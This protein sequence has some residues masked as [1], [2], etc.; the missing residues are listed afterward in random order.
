[1]KNRD[2]EELS[3]K[4][5]HEEGSESWQACNVDT[6]LK[7]IHGQKAQNATDRWKSGLEAVSNYD[8]LMCCIPTTVPLRPSLYH[9]HDVLLL[10]STCILSN[11]VIILPKSWIEQ[12]GASMCSTVL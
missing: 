1:M 2:L 3:W 9:Q 8:G 11:F 4:A 5:K 7:E 12:G 10:F 6:V